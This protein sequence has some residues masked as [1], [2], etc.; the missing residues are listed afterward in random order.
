V[1]VQLHAY[2]PE[3]RLDGDGCMVCGSTD[4][5]TA[6]VSFEE[7]EEVVCGGACFLPTRFHALCGEHHQSLA[8]GLLQ[9]SG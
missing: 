4:D 5:L 1:D 3:T 9:Y 7:D 8:V 2:N 6:I